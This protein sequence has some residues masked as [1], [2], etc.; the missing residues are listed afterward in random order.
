M[1][2][3]RPPAQYTFDHKWSSAI[4]KHGF[5]SV[6]NLLLRHYS[7]IGINAPELRVIIALESYRWDDREPYPSIGS[8]AN[9]LN[10]TPRRLRTLVASLDAKGL[11]ARLEREGNTNTY[12][13]ERL[14]YKLDQIAISSLPV[15]RKDPPSPEETRLERQ[16][17]L[18]SKENEAQQYRNPKPSINKRPEKLGDVLDR[19]YPKGMP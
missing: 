18:S 8:L 3:N 14:I 11:V 4:A 10:V 15:G 1:M 6:P 12:S 16:M 9:L 2:K 5:T 7:S 13:F 19:I 17:K